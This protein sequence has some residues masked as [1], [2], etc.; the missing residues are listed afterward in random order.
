MKRVHKI[1][2]GSTGALVLAVATAVAAAPY[3]PGPGAGGCDGAGPHMGMGM[4]PGGFGPGGQGMSGGGF[5]A[6]SVASLEALKSKLAITADQEAAW[7]AFAKQAAEQSS[8]M[9]AMRAQH[10]A[11]VDAETTAPA[12]MSLRIGAMTQRLA[13]MQAMN[14]ALTDLYAVLT[15]QQRAT[16]DQYFAPG[17][18]GWYRHGRQG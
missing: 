5:G 14:T 17:R 9:Q 7:Q 16:A 6:G 2:A 8:Q 18:Q 12:M 1:I 10:R 3:G 11:T 4:G 13:A 15:P